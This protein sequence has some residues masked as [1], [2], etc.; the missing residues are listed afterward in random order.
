MEAAKSDYDTWTRFLKPKGVV[1]MHDTC[2]DG[3]GVKDFF[4]TIELPKVNFGHCY[5]LGVVSRD[6]K[7]IEEIQAVFRDKLV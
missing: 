2:V 5:G 7:L 4:S 6:E 3:Y 1:L